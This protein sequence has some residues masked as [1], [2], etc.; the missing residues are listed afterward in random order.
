MTRSPQP[1]FAV[2]ALPALLAA[3]CGAEEPAAPAQGGARP[4][5]ASPAA[6]AQPVAAPSAAAVAPAK[7]AVTE[8]KNE[9][10]E[11]YYAYPAQA[12]A[13]PALK[14]LLET[15]LAKGRKQLEAEARDGRDEAR[16]AE[17]E[18]RPYSRDVVWQV[19]TDTPGWLSLSATISADSG[20]AHPNYWFG[21]MA[22]DKAGNRRLDPVE[23]FSSKA[24]LSRAIREPFCNLLDKERARRRGEPVRRNADELFDDCI[25]PA[26]QTVILGSSDRRA[27]NRIGIMVAPYE[28]GPYAEGSYEVTLPVTPAVLDAVKPEYRASFA[29]MR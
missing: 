1:L 15:E 2:V 9:L 20:G 17:F 26:E 10:F 11:F 13:I 23:L 8:D 19:V 6:M 7:E 14:A 3:A 28:A 16:R 25:D 4:S 29:A 21:S 27:F 24:A 12:A 5:A 22:W 18:Y